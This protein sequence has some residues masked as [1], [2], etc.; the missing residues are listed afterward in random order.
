M[1]FRSEEIDKALNF[2]YYNADTVYGV[3]HPFLYVQLKT[4]SSLDECQGQGQGHC[5]AAF[6]RINDQLR[7][8]GVQDSEELVD[9]RWG[10]Y[11][12]GP[13]PGCKYTGPIY[14][15]LEDFLSSSQAWN[16]TWDWSA[17]PAFQA[18]M[19]N[20]FKPPR[21]G[22]EWIIKHLVIS[23]V[24]MY[25]AMNMECDRNDPPA[26]TDVDPGDYFTRA[27]PWLRVTRT[28]PELLHTLSTTNLI[29]IKTEDWY[30]A[31]CDGSYTTL[32]FGFFLDPYDK[33]SWL[34]TLATVLTIA[35]CVLTVYRLV[36]GRSIESFC[37]VLFNLLLRGFLALLGASVQLRREIK[38]RTEVLTFFR[39]TFGVWSLLSVVLSAAYLALFI[40]ELTGSIPARSRWHAP[41]ELVENSFVLYAGT[42][43]NILSPW[44]KR[45]GLVEQE[46]VDVEQ[47]VT[48][49][50]LRIPEGSGSSW[51]DSWLIA[52]SPV[53]RTNRI[54]IASMHRMFEDT[55]TSLSRNETDVFMSTI[56]TCDKS[57]ILEVS[58]ELTHFMDYYKVSRRRRAGLTKFKESQGK[59]WFVYQ[60]YPDRVPSLVEHAY[61]R[62]QALISSGIF[63]LWDKWYGRW[64]PRTWQAAVMELRGRKVRDRGE[65]PASETAKGHEALSMDSNLQSAFYLLGLGALA[66][67]VS[68]CVEILARNFRSLFLICLRAAVGT[69]LKYW[70]WLGVQ[71]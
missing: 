19:T 42:Y 58:G 18:C 27:F 7:L 62:L 21:I 67:T 17:I 66:S 8:Q 44:L 2:E 28:T 48:R 24:R 1:L 6:D 52:S 13:L 51:W 54:A 22:L 41:A 23:E 61:K 57:A 49:R 10:I 36:H 5:R 12:W 38:S 40:R 69:F 9:R 70:Y 47:N 45:M 16:K 4:S 46:F 14:N 68:F 56:S 37:S 59:E 30:L 26:R 39:L 20:P 71:N 15:N 55:Q 43:R 33:A 3:Y 35:V 32:T 65:G 11:S 25:L 53:N 31:T 29:L 60:F 63:E 64:Y 50:D 34:L